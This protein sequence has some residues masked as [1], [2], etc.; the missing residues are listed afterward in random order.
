MSISAVNLT[1]IG[2]GPTKTGQIVAQRSD[3]GKRILRGYGTATLD[4][5]ATSFTVNLID[6]TEIL[7]FTPSA[8]NIAVCGG[9][10]QATAYVN[11]TVSAIDATT[12]TVKLSGE[13]TN[14][15]TLKFLMEIFE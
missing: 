15:K 11:A 14:T 13:G 9:D 6:G 5:S 3:S 4:G 12:A 2:G 7:P 8:A 10:Q 1:Y